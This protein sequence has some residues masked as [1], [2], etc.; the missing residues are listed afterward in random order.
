MNSTLI[1]YILPI[2]LF[3]VFWAI[4]SL[5]ATRKAIDKTLGKM[6]DKMSLKSLTRMEFA[7]DLVFPVIICGLA[8]YT[9]SA[10]VSFAAGFVVG[11]FIYRRLAYRIIK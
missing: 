8:L 4:L 11:G 5:G 6:L 3:V 2:A 7:L 9:G 10:L 1:S